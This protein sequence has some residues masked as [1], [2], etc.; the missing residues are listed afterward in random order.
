M[1]DWLLKAW[2]IV[3]IAM[4]VINNLHCA[5]YGTRI[6]RD[7]IVGRGDRILAAFGVPGAVC[8]GILIWMRL[9]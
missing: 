9:P 3:T 2:L 1:I 8:V 5:I 6:P 4:M 7:E